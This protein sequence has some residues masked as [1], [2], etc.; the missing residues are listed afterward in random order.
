MCVCVCVCSRAQRP[1]GVVLLGVFVGVTVRG[2]EMILWN[3]WEGAVEK[4]K[5][6]RK[7]FLL[8]L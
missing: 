7:N 6:P 2:W 8:D 5:E 4:G 1:P 3:K